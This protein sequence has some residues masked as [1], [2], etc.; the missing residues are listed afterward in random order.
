MLS[1]GGFLM[2]AGP[3][4]S[5]YPADSSLSLSLDFFMAGTASALVITSGEVPVNDH[6]FWNGQIF[7][8]FGEYVGTDIQLHPERQVVRPGGNDQ[9]G[10]RSFRWHCWLPPDRMSELVWPRLC[11]RLRRWLLPRP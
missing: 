2:P 11:A 9:Y 8:T 1:R 3:G 7:Q 5:S 4:G 6:Q 10:R